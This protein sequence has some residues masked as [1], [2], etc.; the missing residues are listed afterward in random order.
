[1]LG[2]GTIEE[3]ILEKQ[4]ILGKRMSGEG[5]GMESRSS[6]AEHWWSTEAEGIR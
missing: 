1:M 2:C 3:G 5:V 4:G 6:G